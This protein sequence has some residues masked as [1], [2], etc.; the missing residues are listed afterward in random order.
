MR[1]N[2]YMR[3]LFNFKSDRVIEGQGSTPDGL[4]IIP[5]L[6]LR[7]HAIHI[8]E[9]SNLMSENNISDFYKDREYEGVEIYVHN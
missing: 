4:D 2:Q 3:I 6:Q 9:I 8:N 5:L 7:V 1:I